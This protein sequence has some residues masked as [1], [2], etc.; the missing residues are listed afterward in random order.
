MMTTSVN[1]I[2]RRKLI[3]VMELDQEAEKQAALNYSVSNRIMAIIGFDL[4]IETLLKVIVGE[5]DKHKSPADKFPGL[6]DQCDDLFLKNSLPSLPSRTH[7]LYMHSLRNDAQHKAKYP[8]ETDVSYCRTY[9]RD[10]CQEVIQNTWGLSFAGISPL[11]WINDDILQELLTI[12]LAD[13][14]TN[15]LKKGLTLTK[16]AFGWASASIRDILPPAD[17]GLY[18]GQVP[19]LQRTTVE[20]INRVLQFMENSA[21]RYAALLSTGIHPVDYK[22]FQEATP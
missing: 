19:E 9:T 4:A 2:T 7:V 13:I 11:E 6:L 16:I 22:R 18:S 3:V 12:S 1:T 21:N 10:F 17:D 5:F 14:Q 15:N 8:N 20:Y